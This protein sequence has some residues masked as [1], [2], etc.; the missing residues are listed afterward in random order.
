MEALGHCF[1]TFASMLPAYRYQSVAALTADT[2]ASRKTKFWGGLTGSS[3][4]GETSQNVTGRL[5]SNTAAAGG[6]GRNRARKSNIT[7]FSDTPSSNWHRVSD[8]QQS[9]FY[10]RGFS[11]FSNSSKNA[12]LVSSSDTEFAGERHAPVNM[13]RCA[14]RLTK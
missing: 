1:G 14:V 2:K 6:W 12:T 4:A 5:N 10:G 11:S 7:G 3:C 9:V 13:S 8:F